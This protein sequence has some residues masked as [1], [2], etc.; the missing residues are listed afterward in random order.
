MTSPSETSPIRVLK[1]GPLGGLALA[2]FS[3][4]FTAGGV[5]MLRDGERMG[6]LV[7]GCFGLCTLV[8]I[9]SAL[10]GASQLALWPDE[11]VIKSMYRTSRIRWRDI[12]SFEV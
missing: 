4:A 9:V 10:P 12:A 11:L 3:A 6:W 5:W 8:G 2:A 1:P 7:A